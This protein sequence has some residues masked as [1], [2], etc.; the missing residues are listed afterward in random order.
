MMM[1]SACASILRL[2]P[3]SVQ[4]GITDPLQQ[5]LR[6][7]IM[8]LGYDIVR[9]G[10]YNFRHRRRRLVVERQINLLLDV[11]ANIGQYARQMRKYGYRG[12]IVSFEPV[13]D[14][15]AALHR[16]AASDECWTCVNAALGDQV[17]RAVIQV[18]ANS[19]SSSFLPMLDEHRDLAPTS[20]F[21]R[22]EEVEV[23]TLAV[24]LEQYAAPA[25]R[26]WLKLD[27]QGY[28]SRI[29]DAAEKVL[30]RLDIIQ[31]EASIR[32][33]YEGEALIEDVIA[34]MRR[35]GFVVVS[36]EP[37]FCD[38]QLWEQVQVD[39]IFARIGSP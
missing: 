32:P 22:E 29:L 8:Q 28:E 7:M 18:A 38:P 27:T 2:I 9:A 21:V 39:L 13:R 24:A 10:P 34:Q 36:I 20:G 1:N 26:V 16:A 5:A 25:D 37:S 30:P 17:G 15:F 4:V 31:L 6:R 23:W 33:M 11:G 14:A 19:Q 12:R 3:K 35:R